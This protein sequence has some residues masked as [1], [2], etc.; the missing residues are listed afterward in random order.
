MKEKFVD[1]KFNVASLKL[2][3]TANEILKEY[4]RLKGTS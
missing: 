3:E 4:D 2:I 1:H